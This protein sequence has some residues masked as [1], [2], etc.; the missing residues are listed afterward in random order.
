MR[1]GLAAALAAASL[2]GAGAASAQNGTV[3]F[4][5]PPPAYYLLTTQASDAR[6]LWVDPAGLAR[7]L[8]ASLGIDLSGYRFDPGGVR[9]GQW[10]GTIATHGVAA[11]WI[12]DRY[13]GGTSLNL[14]NV[15]VGLGDERFSAGA[16]HRWYRGI[17]QGSAW[18]LGIRAAVP[19]GTDVSLLARNVGS[20]RLGDT[21]Y[22]ATLV[23][24]ALVRLL[25][26]RV[27]LAGEWEVAPHGW[28]SVEIRAGGAIAIT[29]SFALLLR[30]DFSPDLK[31]KAL[32]V[33]LDFEGP[34]S[35][36]SAFGLLP[37]T[38]D[39]FDGFGASAALVAR[40]G[41]GTR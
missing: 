7:Q 24:G 28:R 36:V 22:W 32:V 13:P 5:A 30:A 14:Y 39:E 12:H 38:A 37:G 31:R 23:P 40:A 25:D 1:A 17:V 2:L 33:A 18:D 11:G 10:G 41:A 9:L 26:D 27:Q 15:G 34:R 8:E 19:G 16:A 21:T 6:A 35:R 20:P 29:R 4:P 3:P